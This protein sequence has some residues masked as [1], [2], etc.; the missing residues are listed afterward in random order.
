MRTSQLAAFD[1]VACAIPAVENRMKD[2][3]VVLVTTTPSLNDSTLELATRLARQANAVLQFLHLIPFDPISESEAARR[4]VEDVREGLTERWHSALRPTD[5]SVRYR[6]HFVLG[7]GRPEKQIREFVDARHVVLLVVEEPRRSMLSEALWRGV[8]ER[9]VR[10]V[11]C[12]VLIGGPGFLHA[13]LSPRVPHYSSVSAASRVDLLNAIVDARV[14]A[15]C[16]WLGQAVTLV[17]QIAASPAVTTAVM[18]SGKHRGMMEARIGQQLEV[19]MNEHR[20]GC[21]AVGWRVTTSERVW[22]S[23]QFALEAGDRLTEVMRRVATHGAAVSLPMPVK[24]DPAS[25]VLV[26]CARVDVRDGGD[27][28]VELVFDAEADF[29]RILGQPGPLPSFETYAFDRSGLMLSL[30]RF[31]EYLAHTGLLAETG[32]QTPLAIRIAEPSKGPRECWPLTRMA[33][34]ATQGQDGFDATGYRDYRGI[35][36]IGAWRWLATFGFGVAAEV[37]LKS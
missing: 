4:S 30:T 18:L 15:L 7:I 25:L 37:D 21:R 8:A 27:G 33:R 34:E 35:Q 3:L 28:L 29:L 20:Q 17:E 36:V 5:P 19:H 2:S 14:D 26:A 12:P 6:H 10:G 31:P 32:E 23:H 11:D 1:L 24:E 22:A 16:H 13:E 9:L